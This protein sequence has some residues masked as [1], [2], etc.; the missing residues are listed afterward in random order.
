MD[1]TR[2]PSTIARAAAEEIRAL[3][4]RTINAGAFQEPSE[5]YG[6]IG[7]LAQTAQGMP[8][9]I[10]QIWGHLRAMRDD[11]AIRMDN[12][13]EPSLEAERV[14]IELDEAR[15]HLAQA[16]KRLSRASS[17]LSHMGGQW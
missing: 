6:T 14:R 2:E 17:T 13:T 10:Q 8:Q 11:D 3:N 5:I 9:A 15:K 12:D 7:G 1:L 4:H 16:A